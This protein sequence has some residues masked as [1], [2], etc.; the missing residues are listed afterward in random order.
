MLAGGNREGIVPLEGARSDG[1]A[2]LVGEREELNS[3]GLN[4]G[5]RVGLAL[6]QCGG[7]D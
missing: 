7:K 3:G 4:N 5:P 6:G 2:R 1:G